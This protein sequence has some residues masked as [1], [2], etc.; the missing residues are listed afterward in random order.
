ME[1]P[2]NLGGG[3]FMRG[4]REVRDM[5]AKVRYLYEQYPNDPLLSVVRRHELEMLDW[6]LDER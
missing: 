3:L 6:V 5:R 4:E 1:K 2:N